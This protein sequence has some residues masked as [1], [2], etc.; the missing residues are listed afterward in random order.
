[1]ENRTLTFSVI[2]PAYN[3]EAYVRDA[4]DSVL[5]QSYPG[6]ELIA[7]NDGSSDETL[8]ILEQYAA[9]DAR[10]KVFSKENGG[11]VSAVNCGLDK[12]TGDYVCFMGSDDRLSPDLFGQIAACFSDGLPDMIG[13]KTVCCLGERTYAEASTRFDTVQAEFDTDIKSYAE[14]YPAHSEIFFTRD[15][16]KLFKTSLLGD[17]RY[18][19]KYG[20]DADGIFSMLFSHR[21]SSFASIPV[22]GYYWTLREDSVSGR[23]MTAEVTADRIRNW[24]LFFEALSAVS[25]DRIAPMEKQYLDSLIYLL[26]QYA[27]EESADGII[28]QGLD[29]VRQ[30]IRR[31]TIR[32]TRRTRAFLRFPKLYVQFY[33]IFKRF[34]G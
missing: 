29:C 13:F 26:K 1:M 24:I 14:K 25:A 3:S 34:A 16:S 28:E 7:V 30:N 8:H 33:R 31:Y 27:L 6:W 12:A 4:V 20:M 23:K 10:V 19:G 21:A 15:T 22:D 2:M 18:F 9:S 11:Y 32:P 5:R 17:L